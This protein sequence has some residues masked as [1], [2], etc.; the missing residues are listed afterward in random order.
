MPGAGSLSRSAINHQAGAAT[1]MSG[2]FTAAIV[3]L[4]VLVFAPLTR[5]IPKAA[6]AGLLDR[7]GGAPD[8]SAPGPLHPARHRLRRAAHGRDG[9]GDAGGRRGVFDHAGRGGLRAVVHSA[10][11]QAEDSR[12][13]GDRRARGARARAERPCRPAR[14]PSTISRGSCSS[15]RRPSSSDTCRAC[16]TARAGGASATWCC[17]SSACA[18]R[19][20]S[21]SSGS[22][23]SCAMRRATAFTVL[24]AGIRPDLLRG[25]ERLQLERMVAARAL[26]PRG[27]HGVLRDAEG[28]PQG[29]RASGRAAAG[30]CHRLLSRLTLGRSGAHRAPSVPGRRQKSGRREPRPGDLRPVADGQTL[31]ATNA[32]AVLAARKDVE[33]RWHAVALQGGVVAQAVLGR[34]RRCRRRS[35][36]AG[37]GGVAA[38]TAFSSEELAS[39]AALG[40]LPRRA[41][42]EPP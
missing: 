9:A 6:L 19:T 29:L 26:V 18:T 22:S 1:K 38:V 28:S 7:G 27:G 23:G 15:A 25:M 33:L 32:E 40:A 35:G 36:S 16:S 42:R 41:S 2:V 8:R 3:A 31:G 13:R 37:V 39:A 14:W 34:R 20:R 17:A 30:R 4:L 10:R 24:L 11:G 21:A 5:Y 12:A